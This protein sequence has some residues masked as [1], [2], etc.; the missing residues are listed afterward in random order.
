MQQVRRQADV[1]RVGPSH[2]IP[3]LFLDLKQLHWET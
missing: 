2:A 3:K 1:R